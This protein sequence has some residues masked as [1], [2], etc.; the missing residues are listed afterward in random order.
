MTVAIDQTAA[1]AL[2]KGGYDAV[3][4]FT[5]LT[6]GVGN[7]TR[8]AHLQV[9]V[10]PA[11]FSESFEGGLGG[12]QVAPAAA[13]LWHVSSSC[14]SSQPGHSTPN[15]L[16]FGVDSSCTF[17]TG[18][19]VAG[20]ATSLAVQITDTSVAKLRFNYFLTTEHISPF[21][22]ASVQISV[23]NGPFTVAA[24]NNQ[25][26][27][28]LQEGAT[29]AQAEVDL[30]PLLA[31]LTSPVVRIRLAFDSVDSV[32]NSFTGF[33]VDDVQLLA[34]AGAVINSAPTVNA[35]PD[36]A[37]TLPASTT[38]SG[39]V[40]DDG[41]PNPP[42]AFTTAWTMVSGPGTVTFGSASAAVTTATFSTAGSYVLRLTA[43]DSALSATDDVIITVSPVPVNQPPFVNAGFDQTITLPA[44]ATL[45]AT[46]TD[47]GL[48]NPPATVTTLWSVVSG[49]GTVGFANASARVTTA[50]FSVAGSYTLRLTASDSLLSA[51]DDVVVS[52]NPPPNLGIGVTPAGGLSAEGPAGGP[53]A[54]ASLV[55][56]LTNLGSNATVAYQ[57]APS[58]PTSWLTITNGTGQLA[59]GQTAQVTVAINPTAA[60]TLANGGYDAILQFT[61]LT[62]GVGNSTRP[63]HLQVGV[64]VPI[65]SETFEGGLGSFALGTETQNLWHVSA[66]CASLQPGHSTPNALYFGIDSSC[67]YSNG[68]AVAGT[69]TSVPIAIADTSVVKLRFNYFLTTEH[70]SSFDK[71][72]IQVSINGGAFAI[73]ASN[74]QGGVALQETTAWTA[75]EVDLAPLV[76]GLSAPSLRLRV[77][78]DSL[79]AILNST[80]G[81]VVDDIKV[82]GPAG[83][84][85][86]TAPVVSAGPD[87][88]ITLPAA[89]NLNGTV[90]DDGLPAPPALFTTAWSVVSGPGTVTFANFVERVLT[91]ATFSTAGTYVLRLTANDSAT[92]RQRRPGRH[93]ERRA[94]GEQAPVVNA[95]ADADGHAAGGREPDRHGHRRRFAGTAGAVHDGVERGERAGHG[96]VRKFVGG[97]HH[98][99]VL[100]GRHLRVA[101]DR[102]T[103]ARYKP[104]TTSLS[105]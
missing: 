2:A 80:V 7:A 75:G 51:S 84:S 56:T 61:N 5:N 79:D 11:I 53:F 97:A 57:V 68:L 63:A 45:S 90:T 94:A 14:A 36:Q 37:I 49:P 100:D 70:S 54:P 66:A 8:A 78:F 89:A 81:F 17:S 98:G 10:P 12:F 85:T 27:V 23:N 26:G 76:A 34:F 55:Y 25:G 42:A 52:V 48:P 105:R 65:F 59:L 92:V 104:P 64:P 82:L 38:L 18:A 39:A 3:V 15:S 47:D 43:N 74:N 1:A 29:W 4:Q 50:T 24:S 102:R 69:A 32:L 21:D 73:V 62:D 101:T 33:L 95:G 99:D 71:A 30:T 87:Q 83:G 77:A 91:T 96:D 44:G 41:L 35:G 9:G 67:T 16:Y 22:N 13:N 40:S 93:R 72:S 88:T 58:T 103:T 20:A 19:T 46:V 86:N 60:A 28:A 31:G 6:D